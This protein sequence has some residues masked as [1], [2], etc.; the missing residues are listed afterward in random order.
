MRPLFSKILGT[1]G[2]VIQYGCIAHC[3]FE[4]V[5]D[6]VVVSKASE[7]KINMKMYMHFTVHRAVHGTY[8][9]F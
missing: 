5:G 3:T 2:Y 1:V 8:N 4:Y 6:F 7:V 9:F